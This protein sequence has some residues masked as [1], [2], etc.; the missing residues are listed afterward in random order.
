MTE[1]FLFKISKVLFSKYR[2]ILSDLVI[3]LPSRRSSLFLT[4]EFSKFISKPIWLPEFYAIDDFLF[5]INDLKRANNLELFFA[6]YTSYSKHVPNGHSLDRCYNWANTLLDDFNEIDKAYVNQKELF[7]YLSDVKRIENW[8]LDIGANEDRIQDYLHFFKKLDN[9]YQDLTQKL[10]SEKIAYAGLAQRMLVDD[11]DVIKNWLQQNNK[12]KIIFIG[13]DALTISQE[14]IIHYLL[15]NNL[16]EIFWDADNYFISNSEQESGKFLRKY[17]KK[18][19]KPLIQTN[20]DFLKTHKQIDIIGAT[21]QVNQAKILGQILSQKSYTKDELQKTAIILPNENLLLSVLESVPE[22]IKDINV[23]MGYKLSHHPITSIFNDIINLYINKT[24]INA[25]SNTVVNH[26]FKSDVLKLLRNPYFEI[27]LKS[28]DTDIVFNLIELVKKT[29]FTY[30]KYSDIASLNNVNTVSVLKDL[31]AGSFKTGF[32]LINFLRILVNNFLESL[33]DDGGK[34]HVEKECLFIIDEQLLIFHRFSE[35]LKSQLDIQLFAKLFKKVMNSSKL[36][37]SGEP[38]H[39]IQVMGLLESRTID[40]D[41][42]FILSANESELPPSFN[43]N[44]F[45]PVDVK[46]KFNIRTHFDIDAMHANIFFNLIKRPKKTHL[47]YNQDVSSISSGERSRFINQLLYEVKPLS[48]TSIEINQYNV[49]NHFSLEKKN[50]NS[51][52]NIKD[53]FILNKLKSIAKKGFSPSTINSYN[54]CKKQFYFEKIINVSQKEDSE[55]NLDKAMIGSIIHLVLQKLYTPYIGL[56]LDDKVFKE[57]KK[58]IDAEI[59]IALNIYNIYNKDRGKNVLAIEAIRAIIV[60]F[61]NHEK[62]LIQAGNNIKIQYLEHEVL[63]QNFNTKLDNIEINLKGHIDRID[64]FNNTYRIIDYKTGFVEG[65][66]LK[67]LNLD[68]LHSKPKILQLLFYAWLFK[69]ENP[70]KNIPILAGV[71]NLR[72]QNFDFQPCLVNKKSKI[73]QSILCDFEK[74]LDVIFEDIFHPNQNFE[75]LDSDGKCIFCD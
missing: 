1:N 49:L 74:Q 67:T 50:P 57:I 46:L 39:G 22:Q 43:Q 32:D 11:L 47:I 54:F 35:Q 17:K 70:I 14:K 45:I 66:D 9:I 21:K 26:Y 3:V 34:M 30:I 58:N 44:S 60:N 29:E 72:A 37:F 55:G 42:I 7:S 69:K 41:E 13:L 31:F 65:L 62:N 56:S 15:E 27:L 2:E 61:I 18:W 75:H 64:I 24:S 40:F 52:L 4:K 28:V 33:E 59:L 36:N 38:L 6:F 8:Y 63:P 20:D 73:D 53:E 19:P 16:C 23:T 51:I 25:H 48:N 10:V 5:C 71:I 68:D 12:Q